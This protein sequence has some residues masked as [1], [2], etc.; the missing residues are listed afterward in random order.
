VTVRGYDENGK[1]IAIAGATVALGGMSAVTG[2]DGVAT[3]IAPAAPGEVALEATKLGLVRSFSRKV[4]V[5]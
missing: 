1:G 4:E 5:G 2:P 3:V